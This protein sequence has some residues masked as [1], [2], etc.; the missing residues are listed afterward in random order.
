MVDTDAKLSTRE[1]PLQTKLCLLSIHELNGKA[2]W[3]LEKIQYQ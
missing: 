3:Y 1:C 2:K